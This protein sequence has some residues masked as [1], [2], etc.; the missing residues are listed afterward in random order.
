MHKCVKWWQIVKRSMKIKCPNNLRMEMT[1]QGEIQALQSLIFV[2]PLTRNRSFNLFRFVESVIQKAPKAF[3]NWG[4]R[5]PLAPKSG[6]R[7][8]QNI[9][10]KTILE[11]FP[12]GTN[13][14]LE[15]RSTK[16]ILLW[17]FWVWSQRR[18]RVVWRTRFGIL[19]C[20][21]WAKRHPNGHPEPYFF[22]VSMAITAINTSL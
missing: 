12:K 14:W 13:K 18:S 3:R 15:M 2:S 10:Q 9:R 11:T 21:M 19:E 8:V 4:L 17:F 16:M 7:E 6:T 1:K 20:Q 22:I 5:V